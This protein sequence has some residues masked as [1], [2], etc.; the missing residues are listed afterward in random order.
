MPARTSAR[1][2]TSFPVAATCVCGGRRMCVGGEGGLWERTHLPFA[3]S[4][5]RACRPH[6]LCPTLSLPGSVWKPGPSF[7]AASAPTQVSTVMPFRLLTIFSPSCFSIAYF[8]L[9]GRTRFI[10]ARK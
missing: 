6:A 4:T 7:P 5:L 10:V 1:R 3:F 9:C 2:H 8:L